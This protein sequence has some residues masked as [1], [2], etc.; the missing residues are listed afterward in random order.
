M[1]DKTIE[2]IAVGQNHNL[3]YKKNGDLFGF[4]KKKIIIII[5]HKL[6]FNLKT[7]SNNSG[8]KKKILKK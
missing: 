2:M 5:S 1:N 6:I 7:G 8:K 4:G 3:I